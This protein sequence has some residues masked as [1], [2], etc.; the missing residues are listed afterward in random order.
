[1]RAPCAIGVFHGFVPLPSS[2]RISGFPARIDGGQLSTAIL[3]CEVNVI[4]SS[5]F[6]SVTSKLAVAICACS[7]SPR[8]TSSPIW[9]CEE[10]SNMTAES[11]L[12]T[13]SIS[14]D[15]L[16]GI[17][18]ADRSA[19][20]VGVL[21]MRT[22]GLGFTSRMYI[23]TSSLAVTR[24]GG[25]VSLLRNADGFTGKRRH[26]AS[27]MGPGVERGVGV[28][29]RGVVGV[30]VAVITGSGVAVGVCDGVGVKVAGGVSVGVGVIVG[31]SV[32][33][34]VG[35]GVNAGK[36]NS[37][38]GLYPG[39]MVIIPLYSIP[40]LVS[41]SM[42]CSPGE[43][44]CSN[45]NTPSMLVFAVDSPIR[46]TAFGTFRPSRL[47]MPTTISGFRVAVGVGVMVGVGV[48]VLVGGD[49][50]VWLGVG[51]GVRVGV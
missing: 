41:I 22:G 34:T 44:P 47:T 10:T 15:A 26:S 50:G 9:N 31:V 16:S 17:P 4:L 14:K 35:V 38:K 43:I 36:G 28:P 23:P 2:K 12:V 1:M 37:S 7:F 29:S 6:S 33:G 48:E 30:G 21:L 5:E 20:T 19:Q 45:S 51:V 27:S 32:G 18:N 8:P 25:S 39:Y 42:E 46:T 40:T 3:S 49:V 11:A 24:S 13:T